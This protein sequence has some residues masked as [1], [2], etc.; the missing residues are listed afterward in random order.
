MNRAELAEAERDEARALRDVYLRIA[1]V[2]QRRVV[3]LLAKVDALTVDRDEAYRVAQRAATRIATMTDELAEA[4]AALSGRT[5]SCVC[6]GAA[7]LARLRAALAEVGRL[8]AAEEYAHVDLQR[9]VAAL[10]AERL[11]GRRSTSATPS[12]AESRT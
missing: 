2:A 10:V 4:R 6:G 3:R 9:D 1:A 12:D 11:L 7:E 5:V 8:V